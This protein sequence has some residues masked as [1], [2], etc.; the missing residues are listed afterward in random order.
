M[1]DVGTGHVAIYPLLLHRLRPEAAVCG[2]EIDEVS[3]EHARGV[4]EKNGIRPVPVF[5]AAESVSGQAE[6]VQGESTPHSDKPETEAGSATPGGITL[7]PACPDGSLL[8]HPIYPLRFTLCNPPFFAS[9]EEA[10][11]SRSTKP[12]GTSA[13]TCAPNEEVTRGGEVA[14]VSR[15]IDESAGKDCTWFTSLVGKYA[16][17]APLVRKAKESGNYALVRLQQA[18]TVRWVLVWSHDHYRLPD[19][20]SAGMSFE[21]ES[22]G[23]K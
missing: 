7:L 6:A 3:L 15:L 11:E 2:S 22:D 20:S 16:S 1:L 8:S 18:R 21:Y 23:R 10:L 14:F 12:V 9:E 5:D 13:P 4:L 19:V 17:L